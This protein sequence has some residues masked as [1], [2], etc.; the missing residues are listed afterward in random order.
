MHDASISPT[1][2]TTTAIAPDA[3]LEAIRVV[4]VAA[5]T[6]LP[7]LGLLFYLDQRRELASEGAGAP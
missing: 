7:S 4:L 5:V 6:I 3:T 2:S 1:W